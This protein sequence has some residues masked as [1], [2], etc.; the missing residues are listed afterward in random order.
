MDAA[1]GSGHLRFSFDLPGQ[2]VYETNQE[3][4]PESECPQLSPSSPTVPE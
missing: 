1:Q 4:L 2:P 3:I